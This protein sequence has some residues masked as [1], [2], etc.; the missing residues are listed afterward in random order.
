MLSEFLPVILSFAGL[1]L[2]S[3]RSNAFE[4][5]NGTFMN[6]TFNGVGYV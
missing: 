6:E 4:A 2:V 3:L 5:S 1:S